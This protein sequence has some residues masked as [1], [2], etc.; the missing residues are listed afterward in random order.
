VEAQSRDV[1]CF[2]GVGIMNPALLVV[3]PQ[4]DFFGAD[5]PNL[6]EFQRVLPT[7]NSAVAF[8]EKQ[9]WLVVFIQHTSSKKKP[10]THSWE[11]YE[12]FNGVEESSKISKKYPNSFW[13][14]QLH[15]LLK[16]KQIDFVVVAGF[17]SEYCVLST[18][19]GAYERGYKGIILRDGIASLDNRYTSFVLNISRN[20]SL[21]EFLAM[22]K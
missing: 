6:V 8:F 20:S 19:R 22:A 9:G 7:I 21:D 4:N 15:S 16:S 1:P 2:L 17:C 11:I 3:D 12:G 13:K 18:F 14:T 5:N 10:G